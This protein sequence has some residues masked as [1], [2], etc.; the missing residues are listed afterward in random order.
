MPKRKSNLFATFQDS[1]NSLL[2]RTFLLTTLASLLGICAGYPY[3]ARWEDAYW[4]LQMASGRSE[5]VL[6][7]YAGRPLAALLAK[8]LHWLSGM[9]IEHSFEVIGLISLNTRIRDLFAPR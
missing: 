8:W 5:N 2:R 9:S 1:R 4:Y 3:F 7:P 6:E